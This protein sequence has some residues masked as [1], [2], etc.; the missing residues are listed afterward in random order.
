MIASPAAFNLHSSS[1]CRSFDLVAGFACLRKPQRRK[2]HA[3]SKSPSL[4]IETP[5]VSV[6]LH[7]PRQGRPLSSL[8]NST[9][10]DLQHISI[11]LELIDASVYLHYQRHGMT[12]KHQHTK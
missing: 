9:V 4:L 8:R 5:N 12:T 11:F 6:L 1:Q 2:I 10:K 3:D 7:A